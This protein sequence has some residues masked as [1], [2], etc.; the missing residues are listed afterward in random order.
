MYAIHGYDPI[1]GKKQIREELKLGVDKLIPAHVDPD[2]LPELTKDFFGSMRCMLS[3]VGGRL[4]LKISIS[5]SLGMWMAS[6]LKK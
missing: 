6:I 5:G 2:Q 3:R 1:D 4:A